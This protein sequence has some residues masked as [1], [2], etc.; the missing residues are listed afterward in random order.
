MMSAVASI[1]AEAPA[2]DPWVGKYPMS[3]FTKTRSA[4]TVGKGHLSASFK[5]Q[6]FDWDELRSTSGDYFS[7][8]SA[9][10]KRKLTSV[11][12][13]KYGWAENHHLALGI[14]YFFNDFNVNGRLNDNDGFGNLYLFEKWKAISETNTRPAVAF[15]AWVYL[16]TGDA[17]RKLG[18][19]DWAFKLTTEVSK[20]W[21][22]FSLHFNPGYTWGEDSD[23]RTGEINI[24][25]IWNLYKDF[26]PAIEYN[27]T[28]KK[29]IGNCHDI[30]PGFIWKFA[31]GWS[32]KLA[33][34][35]NV[36]TILPEKDAVGVV[37]KLF[38]RW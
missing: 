25:A 36:D 31:K 21:E 38:Y 7:R 11:L 27:Y 1:A 16:P 29:G 28:D 17:D 18:D 32:F 24:C 2:L 12:C 22:H 14:P 9:D 5:V 26:T 33:A 23:V 34:V 3:L 8:P 6:H 13:M 15:D 20:A 4:N 19:D 30:V 35:I 10:T 37:G